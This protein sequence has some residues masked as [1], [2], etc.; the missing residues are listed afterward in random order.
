MVG[1]DIYDIFQPSSEH[2]RVFIAG[3]TGHGVQ[4]SLRTIVIKSEY[5]RLKH[6]HGS[7]ETLLAE[8]NQRLVSQYAAILWLGAVG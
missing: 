6:A 7:P 4:A 5:D 8:L 2:Y 3:A 1:G